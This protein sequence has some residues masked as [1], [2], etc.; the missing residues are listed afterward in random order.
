MVVALISRSLFH[1]PRRRITA[2][3]AAGV[4]SLNTACFSCW[5][6]T[7]IVLIIPGVLPI[8]SKTVSDDRK[9]RTF[10]QRKATVK[11]HRAASFSTPCWP[12][13]VP[14][15]EM[16]TTPSP[17]CRVWTDR[18]KCNERGKETENPSPGYKNRSSSGVLGYI[19]SLAFTINV[20]IISL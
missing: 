16:S 13:R 1:P 11:G 15:L 12:Y 20:M 18:A 10:A 4:S 9:D 7:I 5:V 19:L 8:K 17:P 6:C 3:S 2:F 14:V